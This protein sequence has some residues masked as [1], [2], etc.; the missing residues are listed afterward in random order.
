MSEQ[1][2]SGGTAGAEVDSP[3]PRERGLIRHLHLLVLIEAINIASPCGARFVTASPP[4]VRRGSA[5]PDHLHLPFGLRPWFALRP[6]PAFNWLRPFDVGLAERSR[7]G[8]WKV[9]GR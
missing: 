6:P 9:S 8:V 7:R 1:L 4:D 5:P 2:T 3:S